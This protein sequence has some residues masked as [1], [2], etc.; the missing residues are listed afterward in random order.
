MANLRRIVGV[1]NN[2]GLTVHVES[3]IVIAGRKGKP[4]PGRWTY[5]PVVRFTGRIKHGR[6]L[7]TAWMHLR[8]A[9]QFILGEFVVAHARAGR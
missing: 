3:H 8:Q 7:R 5:K 6:K 1:A 9:E 4:R 2:L